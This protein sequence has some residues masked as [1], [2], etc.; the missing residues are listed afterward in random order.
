MIRINF[1]EP[2]TVEWTS[3]RQRC[4]EATN[5]LLAAVARGE[6]PVISKVLYK[7]QK[8]VYVG[9]RSQF[10]GKCAY[11]E[12]SIAEGHP[13]DLDHF[14]PKSRI[15]DENAMVVVVRDENGIEQPHPG[16]YWLA[17]DWRNLLP[18]CFDCNSP[19]KGKS[20]GKRI[21]KWDY[22]PVKGVRATAPGE[23]NVEEPLLLHPVFQDPADHLTIDDTGVFAAITP[24]GQMCIDVFG[25]NV[26]EALVEGRK[27]TYRGIRAKILGTVSNL[28]R[29][30]NGTDALEDLSELEAF[31]AGEKPFSAAA[32]VAIQLEGEKLKPLIETLI[33]GQRLSN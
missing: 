14:R 27:L 24:E 8:E 9:F 15:T 5:A 23:E 26:R 33:S 16:Y 4:E 10:H 21:G 1:Q 2:A 3:W 25:L 20:Q 13:G 6:S 28:Q 31:I 19:S 7:G 29:D 17:Y 11:C 30:P 32:R 18:S 12:C 22:F